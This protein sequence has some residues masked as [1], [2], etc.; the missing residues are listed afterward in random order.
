MHVCECVR[1]A[2]ACVRDSPRFRHGSLTATA[3]P[4]TAFTKLAT[5]S[6]IDR[7][8]PEV[9]R[10]PPL[11]LRAFLSAFLIS[12]LSLSSSSFSVLLLPVRLPFRLVSLLGSAPST[13]SFAL[14]RFLPLSSSLPLAVR[15]P[16]LDT[17]RRTHANQLARARA[18][19]THAKQ[20]GRERQTDSR[21]IAYTYVYAKVRAHN[22]R[23]GTEDR[24]ASQRAR[25]RRRG[26]PAAA[27]WQAERSGA[28]RSGQASNSGSRAGSAHL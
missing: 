24:G 23:G 10:V 14:R 9:P 18:R 20:R 12:S 3:I 13:S 19:V 2:R 4:L 6:R 11:Q 15:R 22:R 27:G 7:G 26:A 21:L 28:E 8:F 16:R 1:D 17:R 5:L 25:T